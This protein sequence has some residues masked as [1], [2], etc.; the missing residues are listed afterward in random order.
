M[1]L[2][3]SEC[4]CT[5]LSR[6]GMPAALGWK[7]EGV[8]KTA[9]A[10][11][12]EG[13]EGGGTTHNLDL[14]FTTPIFPCSS[15]ITSLFS[16]SNSAPRSRGSLLQRTQEVSLCSCPSRRFT[17]CHSRDRYGLTIQISGLPFP[18]AGVPDMQLVHSQAFGIR[19]RH[20]RS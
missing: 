20:C 17:V 18:E 9:R 6:R 5:L 1:W 3:V 13:R 16:P 4:Y 14:D 8:S 15:P 19:P 2:D 11:G 7:H 10:H 12:R